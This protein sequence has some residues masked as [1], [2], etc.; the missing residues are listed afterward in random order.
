MLDKIEASCCG[1][2]FRQ[3]HVIIE[4]GRA[5]CVSLNDLAGLLGLDKSTL[6]RITDNLVRQGLAVREP[7]TEDRRYIKIRLTESGEKMFSDI[8]Q[9][10]EEYYQKIYSSLP[11]EKRNQVLESLELLLNILKT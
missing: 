2:G 10:M 8:E 7:D 11:P 4:V 5:G 6:S 3:C 9:R 1:I